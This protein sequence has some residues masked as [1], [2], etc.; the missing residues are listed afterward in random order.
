[1]G[2]T[3]VENVT[4][5]A[6]RAAISYRGV[7]HINFPTDLQD[8]EGGERTPRNRPHHESSVLEIV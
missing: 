4:N 8:Q 5:L 3:H 7:S 1:M 2:P 6:C